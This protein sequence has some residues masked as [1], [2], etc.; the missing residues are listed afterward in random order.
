MVNFQV[1]PDSAHQ[2]DLERCQGYLKTDYKYPVHGAHGRLTYELH[3]KKGL[4]H[5][6][7]NTSSNREGDT[8]NKRYQE[9][10]FFDWKIQLEKTQ[11]A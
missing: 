10:R 1:L 7:I 6:G 3:F 11:V 5:I 4:Q 9:I 8:K 2:A